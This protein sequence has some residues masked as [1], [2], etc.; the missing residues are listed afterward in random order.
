MHVACLR[1]GAEPF[2]Q[3][4]KDEMMR[5]GLGLVDQRRAELENPIELDIRLRPVPTARPDLTTAGSQ[6]D[7]TI[8]VPQAGQAARAGNKKPSAAVLSALLAKV[9]QQ[10]KKA[11]ESHIMRGTT[12]T[13]IVG[14]MRK[15]LLARDIFRQARDGHAKVVAS[16]IESWLEHFG[17]QQDTE[18]PEKD[19]ADRSEKDKRADITVWSCP[20]CRGPI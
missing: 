10:I 16:E 8:I 11:A 12:D 7:G 17:E 6:S 1:N 19:E 15:V 3:T 2:G 4:H 13:G 20:R 9:P 18:D 5:T 14:N